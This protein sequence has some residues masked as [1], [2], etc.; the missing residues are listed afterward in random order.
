MLV[1]PGKVIVSPE[2]EMGEVPEELAVTLLDKLMLWPVKVW[3]LFK[4]A[5]APYEISK[6]VPCKFLELK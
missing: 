3:L 1:G 2:T 5:A 4:V 6:I